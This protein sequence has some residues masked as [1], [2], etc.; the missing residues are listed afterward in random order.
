MQKF[1]KSQEESRRN[2]RACRRPLEEKID[3]MD[4]LWDASRAKVL[5]KAVGAKLHICLI[6]YVMRGNGPNYTCK[7]EISLTQIQVQVQV[8]ISCQE[9][10]GPSQEWRMQMADASVIAISPQWDWKASH[11]LL[12]ETEQH[13]C[14]W[15]SLEW[16]VVDLEER[17][18]RKRKKKSDTTPINA[19]R[20]RLITE[21]SEKTILVYR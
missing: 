2:T 11:H 8:Q 19:T 1:H 13:T 21:L 9:A 4:W 16:Q 18:E 5:V 17:I 7:S 3:P 12:A 15:K 10:K 14:T 20:K 6:D